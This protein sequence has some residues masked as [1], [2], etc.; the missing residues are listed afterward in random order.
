MSGYAVAVIWFGVKSKWFA[1]DIDRLKKQTLSIPL[2]A[3]IMCWVPAVLVPNVGIGVPRSDCNTDC[4]CYADIWLYL[5]CDCQGHD[6]GI[7]KNGC[8]S[9]FVLTREL[10]MNFKYRYIAI[11]V[12]AVAGHQNLFAG[13]RV[14][15]GS[16][17][18][19]E[20]D[21]AGCARGR[22]ASCH[23]RARPI[24]GQPHSRAG[25]GKRSVAA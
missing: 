18:H 24:V 23:A 15:D 2:V 12:M 22:G 19:S 3:L 9:A 6:S 5:D 21:S 8:H 1:D 25:D 16:H 7:H 10:K 4:D 17:E 20:P 13:Y 11:A 14:I